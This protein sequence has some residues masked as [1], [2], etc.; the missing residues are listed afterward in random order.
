MEDVT[1]NNVSYSKATRRYSLL[2]FRETTG[3]SFLEVTADIRERVRLRQ[4]LL[5]LEKLT[6]MGNMAAGTAHHLNTPLAAMLLRIQMMRER[7]GADTAVDL[8][9]LE[10]GVVSC[11]QFVQRLLDFSWRAPLQKQPEEVV[12]AVR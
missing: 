2:P 8:E 3:M 6:T 1:G 5:N 12:P 7:A 4:T 11:R 10:A 9:S